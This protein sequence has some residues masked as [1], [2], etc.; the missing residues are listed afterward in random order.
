ML[1]LTITEFIYKDDDII[2]EKVLLKQSSELN[3]IPNSEKNLIK[4]FNNNLKKLNIED[5]GVDLP[6]VATIEDNLAHVYQDVSYETSDDGEEITKQISLTL[7][8]EQ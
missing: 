7:S 4:I 1:N 6:Y 8:L 3:T 2:Q 5:D